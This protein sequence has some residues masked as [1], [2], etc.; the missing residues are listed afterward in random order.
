MQQSKMVS[1][2]VIF[3]L[4][5]VT[6]L[7]PIRQSAELMIRCI[8]ECIRWKMSTACTG[9]LKSDVNMYLLCKNSSIPTTQILHMHRPSLILYTVS[10]QCLFCCRSPRNGAAR[11]W[12][13]CELWLSTH[14]FYCS[15]DTRCIAG[16]AV[17]IIYQMHTSVL[18]CFG[19]PSHLMFLCVFNLVNHPSFP[20]AHKIMWWK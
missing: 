10:C 15:R 5:S 6:L 1:A 17:D 9:A 7:F 8:E 14:N 12:G 19:S 4:H 20:C 3:H 13:I 11:V 2:K 18:G 16:G